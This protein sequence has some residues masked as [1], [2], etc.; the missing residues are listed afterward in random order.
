MKLFRRVLSLLVIAL[1]V[2]AC[3]PAA[4]PAS[5]SS[6]A[7]VAVT[8]GPAGYGELKLGMTP[9]QAKAT[10]LISEPAGSAGTACGRYA[11][12][13]GAASNGTEGRLY[14]SKKLGLAAIYGYAG[15]GTPEG[16]AVGTSYG[17]L[18]EAYPGWK[19][20]GGGERDGRGQIA[21]PGNPAAVYRIEVYGGRVV[22]LA[23]QV[24]N[25]DCYE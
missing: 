9:D 25:Q 23:V 12:L 1:P 19:P 4:G 17:K 5:T 20:V 7:A 22:Q 16:V 6:S 3:T 2:A 10:G 8:L 13:K 21:V 14:F 18:H 15:L 24:K 11:Y